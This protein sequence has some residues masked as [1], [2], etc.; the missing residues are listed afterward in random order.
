M[1]SHYSSSALRLCTLRVCVLLMG[2][3]FS[4]CSGDEDPYYT[5]KEVRTPVLQLMQKVSSPSESSSGSA[6][7]IELATASDGALERW[8]QQY[9][10]RPD[11]QLLLRFVLLSPEGGSNTVQ[12]ESIRRLQNLSSAGRGARIGAATSLNTRPVALADFE[13]TELTTLN[14]TV[15]ESPLRIEERYFLLKLPSAESLIAEFLKSGALPGFTLSYQSKNPLFREDRGLVSFTLLPDPS[16]PLF[17]AAANGQIGDGQASAADIENAR[18]L[19]AT[20]VP[21]KIVG[22]TPDGGALASNSETRLELTLQSDPDAG[23]ASRV[24][25]FVSSGK[26]TNS[27][28]RRPKWKPEKSGSVVAFA[29][30]RDLQGGSD[31]TYRVFTAQ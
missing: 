15:L 19:S 13:P 26:I 2:F 21:P 20:N 31:F 6:N 27:V 28:S 3:I 17:E 18:K 9:P 4:G 23:A 16:S 24:Q 10:V 22:M 1:K 5:V 14:K 12:L 25:W 29:M 7:C 8:C 30:L 11:G